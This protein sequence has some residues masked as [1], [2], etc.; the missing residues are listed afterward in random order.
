MSL[1]MKSDDANMI[2][3]ILNELNES[4][5]DMN[6]SIPKMS[7]PPPQLSAATPTHGSTYQPQNLNGGFAPPTGG[8]IPAMPNVYNHRVGVTTDGQYIPTVHSESEG[9][10]NSLLKVI[11]KPLLVAAIVFVVF[12]TYTRQLLSK[13]IPALFE[14]TNIIKQQGVTLFLALTI[15]TIVIGIDKIL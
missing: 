7:N 13:H 2:D 10:W 8:Q 1:E 14:S 5:S 12:N 9:K 15:G 6:T 4:T 11:R 3:D